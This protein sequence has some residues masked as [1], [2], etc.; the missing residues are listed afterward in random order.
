MSKS[1]FE[2]QPMMFGVIAMAL[3]SVAYLKT[4]PDIQWVETQQS[5]REK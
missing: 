1:L 5:A 2:W 3:I 4:Q